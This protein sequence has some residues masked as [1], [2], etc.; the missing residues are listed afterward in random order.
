[1]HEVTLPNHAALLKAAHD[2]APLPPALVQLSALV[3]TGS[4]SPADVEAIVRLDAPLTG[5][6]L[7]YSNSA[8]SASY[9]R[10]GTVRDAVVRVGVGP[11]LSFVAATTLRPQFLHA[12]PAYGLSE[13]EL[14]R[15]SV[16]AALACEVIAQK[17]QVEVPPDSFT[18]SL[19]HDVGKVVLARFL[20]PGHLR[21][22]AAAREQGGEAS[23]RAEIDILGMHHGELGGLIGSHWNLPPR[24]IRGITHHH[25]PAAGEDI[26]CDVVHLANVLA[27]RVGT[28]YVATA[29]DLDA[30]PRALERLGLTAGHLAPLLDTVRHRLAETV[31][32]FG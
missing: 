28:G 6:L 22:L 4:Y 16:A 19:L 13:G 10:I 20:E 17:A 14:W 1:M 21:E 7:Q 23:L 11:V 15:H 18:A 30:D 2:L 32:R 9:M 24:V 12:I 26:I 31:E 25:A 5:R 3:A 27:K 8:A 29:S